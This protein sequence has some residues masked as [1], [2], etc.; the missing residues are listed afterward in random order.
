M[1]IFAFCGYM[2]CGKDTAADFIVQMHAG[3][4]KIAIASTLKETCR[5]LFDFN[6]DQVNGNDKDNVDSR[7]GVTPRNVLQFMGTEV[8]Q[9]KIEE[10]M[11][12]IGRTFWINQL[13]GKMDKNPNHGYV[14]CDMRFNHEYHALKK[15]YGNDVVV[16]KIENYRARPSNT[17][18]SEHEWMSIPS[19]ITIENNGTLEEFYAKLSAM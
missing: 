6:H 14:I 8:M 18:V 1:K 15:K 4:E 2:R 9:F 17:H 11:P 16:V 5:V 13:I 3:F 7:Y 12:G 19:D 10:L